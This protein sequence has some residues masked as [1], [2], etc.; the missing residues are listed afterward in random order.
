[1]SLDNVMERARGVLGHLQSQD[2]GDFVR[3]RGQL[4]KVGKLKIDTIAVKIW[5]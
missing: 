5:P 4:K 3:K 2:L 1:M